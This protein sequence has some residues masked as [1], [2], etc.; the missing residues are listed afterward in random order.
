MPTGSISFHV[1][2]AAAEA[3]KISREVTTEAG[4]G[5]FRVVPEISN[6]DAAAFSPFPAEDGNGYGLVIKLNKK[7]TRKLEVISTLY[8]GKLL[9]SIINGQP[10]DIVRIDKPI[11]DGTLVIW[12][13]VTLAQIN[14]YDLIVPR[15]GENEETWKERVKEIKK[16][17]KKAAKRAKKNKE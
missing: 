17:Y 15:I 2:G 8:Q 12:Q 7:A 16:N 3:P 11:K 14:S 6:N 9:L 13:G 10:H 5:F 1:E 4:K